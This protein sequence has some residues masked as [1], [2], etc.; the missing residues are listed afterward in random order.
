MLR[1]L[2]RKHELDNLKSEIDSG[3]L[4][5]VSISS[6]TSNLVHYDQTSHR[7]VMKLIYDKAK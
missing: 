4:H 1:K 2:S 7:K 3:K 5:S 6:Q